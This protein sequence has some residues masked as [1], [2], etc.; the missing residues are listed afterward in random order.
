LNGEKEKSKGS[1]KMWPLKQYTK[2]N[3]NKSRAGKFIR[4]NLL[5]K[6]D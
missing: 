4:A 5:S 1:K 2:V 3:I 6:S